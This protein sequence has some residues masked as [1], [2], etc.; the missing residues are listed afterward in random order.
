V[1]VTHED[2]QQQQETV[3]NILKDLDATNVP[4]LTVYNKR[5]KLTEDFIPTNHPYAL[6]SAYNNQDLD[7]L[8]EQV[9]NEIKND[10]EYFTIYLDPSEGKVMHQIERKQLLMRVNLIVRKINII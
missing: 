2:K 4:I 3:I 9:E 7:N 5:D 8:L 1:D 10:W 6:I